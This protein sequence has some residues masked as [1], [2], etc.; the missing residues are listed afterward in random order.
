MPQVISL[1]EVILT[2]TVQLKMNPPVYRKFSIILRE[3]PS[4]TS[5]GFLELE[6]PRFQDKRADLQNSEARVNEVRKWI[7]QN[8][9]PFYSR[10]K[11]PRPFPASRFMKEYAEKDVGY[12]SDGVF[13]A[14]MLC[15]G[16]DASSGSELPTFNV[17]KKALD[18]LKRSQQTNHP[19]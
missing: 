11:N 2:N 3:F 13:I 14:S 10:I 15:E 19:N 6:D 4:L 8:L 5:E 7:D 9:N 1:R 16:F 17:A 18:L 12:I